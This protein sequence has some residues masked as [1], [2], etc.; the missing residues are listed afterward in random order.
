MNQNDLRVLGLSALDLMDGGYSDDELAGTFGDLAAV[1]AGALYMAGFTV[2]VLAAERE[3]S[4]PATVDYLRGLLGNSGGDD[5][6]G[7]VRE[8]R[9]PR[10][11]PGGLS[12]E[13]SGSG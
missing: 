6:S 12:A 9:R 5:G 3:E 4:V 2:Q 1:A 10:P 7:G 13:A 8:P 11:S